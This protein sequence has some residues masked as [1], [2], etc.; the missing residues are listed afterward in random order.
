MIWRVSKIF[1]GDERL[2]RFLL[3]E[4]TQL[5]S[6]LLKLTKMGSNGDTKHKV[7]FTL[8][9]IGLMRFSL[10]WQAIVLIRTKNLFPILP[11]YCVGFYISV[12]ASM[13]CIL[14]S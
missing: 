1:L 2:T 9:K 3:L 4:L 7:L 6:T 8:S 13:I 11:E 10:S 14:S 5:R 12:Q